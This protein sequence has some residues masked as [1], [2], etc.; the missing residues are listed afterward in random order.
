MFTN[1]KILVTGGTGS[2]GIEL[3]RQLLNSKPSRIIIFS[4]NENSQ[5][6]MRRN[7]VDSRLSFCIRGYKRQRSAIRSL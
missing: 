3:I 5:V 6:L 1:S 7:F 2:W 4:R